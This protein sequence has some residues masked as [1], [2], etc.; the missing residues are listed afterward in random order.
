VVYF[1][2]GIEYGLQSSFNQIL[3]VNPKEKWDTNKN[4]LAL[5]VHFN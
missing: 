4:S 3:K 5:G 1:E 2:E